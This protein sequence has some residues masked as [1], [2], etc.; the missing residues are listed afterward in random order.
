[1]KVKEIIFFIVWILLLTSCKSKHKIFISGFEDD[2]IVLKSAK[3]DVKTLCVDKEYYDLYRIK[4]RK[5]YTCNTCV[6][7]LL[8]VEN[9]KE[10]G[11]VNVNF[12][13]LYYDNE[14]NFSEDSSSIFGYLMYK[15]EQKIE[16]IGGKNMN[17]KFIFNKKEF[18][19][20]PYSELEIRLYALSLGTYNNS[21]RLTQ[22][23]D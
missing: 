6:S 23:Q 21:I 4:M 9:F 8:K 2:N 13:E 20:F 19:N 14:I 22:I 15:H 7:K 16:I 1:M 11:S 17:C 5:T 3:S 18:C 12:A 10:D